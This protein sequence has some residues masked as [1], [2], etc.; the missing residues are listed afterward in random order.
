M[1]GYNACCLAYGQT[2]AGKT[3]TMLGSE[4]SLQPGVGPAHE[5]GLGLAP[6]IFREIFQ[7]RNPTAPSFPPCVHL[8]L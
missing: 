3:Y 1:A 2:G 5:S 6:R 7:V 8:L 4:V